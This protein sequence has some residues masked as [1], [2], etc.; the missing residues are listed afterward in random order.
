MLAVLD[1]ADAM[2]PIVLKVLDARLRADRTE[3]PVAVQSFPGSTAVTLAVFELSSVG[4]AVKALLLALTSSLEVLEAKAIRQVVLEGTMVQG[5]LQYPSTSI[6]DLVVELVT[7]EAFFEL[8]IVFH[9]RARVKGSPAA[10]GTILAESSK[11]E[12]AIAA[13]VFIAVQPRPYPL[14]LFG[15]GNLVPFELAFQLQP[16]L[17]AVGVLVIELA[18]TLTHSVS[19]GSLEEKAL[20]VAVIDVSI[21]KVARPVELVVL[22]LTLVA[23]V[24]ELLAQL[25]DKLLLPRA[26][27]LA[28][29][30]FA[31]VDEAVGCFVLALPVKL[32]ILPM[33]LIVR[34]L[35]AFVAAFVV[36][37]RHLAKA[38]REAV[39]HFTLIHGEIGIHGCAVTHVLCIAGF[40]LVEGQSQVWDRIA[41]SLYSK[42][43]RP[44]VPR[45]LL[46]FFLHV[47][48]VHL[49]ELQVTLRP[50]VSQGVQVLVEGT[51]LSSFRVRLEP[52]G[53]PFTFEAGDVKRIEVREGNLPRAQVRSLQ[54]PQGLR[55]GLLQ[56]HHPIA[57]EEVI[58]EVTL[59]DLGHAGEL[60]IAETTTLTV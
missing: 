27:S 26:V 22:P 30:P 9:G 3:L 48:V 42:R 23:T 31:G 38:V 40:G 58:A 5:V 39:F 25:V 11:E 60:T 19:E 2:H 16:P 43:I 41:R 45:E 53:I 20:R 7:V 24:A 57:M 37:L 33:A 4:A 46:V 13:L 49:V 32:A 1:D 56:T 52:I 51:E 55:H 54:S 50:S 28:R 29:S 10:Q 14:I 59:V 18:L 21:V 12:F 47:C 36:I 44:E 35:L 15:S 6:S 8:R 17:L 34:N